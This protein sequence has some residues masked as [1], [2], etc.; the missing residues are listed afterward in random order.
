MEGPS[1]WE[2]LIINMISCLNSYPHEGFSQTHTKEDKLAGGVYTYIGCV[3]NDK[4]D[5]KAPP[6]PTSTLT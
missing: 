1:D 3:I 4:A 5:A 2:G 6:S